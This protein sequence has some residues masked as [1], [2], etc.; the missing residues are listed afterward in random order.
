MFS[1]LYKRATKCQCRWKYT[2]YDSADLNSLGDFTSVCVDCGKAE[3]HIN[4]PRYP[5][6]TREASIEIAYTGKYLQKKNNW[7][8]RGPAAPFI[9]KDGTRYTEEDYQKSI[10]E[11]YR[12]P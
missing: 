12:K 11:Y 9:R 7:G 6:C 8:E 4:D 10:A 5:G 1:W 2:I 3:F